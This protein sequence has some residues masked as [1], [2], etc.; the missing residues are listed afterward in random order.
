MLI[1]LSIAAFAT[2]TDLR[3]IMPSFS[4]SVNRLIKWISDSSVMVSSAILNWA[5]ST[6]SGVIAAKPSLIV[7]ADDSDSLKPTR[8]T[9]WLSI[10]ILLSF[11]KLKLGITSLLV[12][13]PSKTF[14]KVSVVRSIVLTILRIDSCR[15]GL[16]MT[17]IKLTNKLSF[18]SRAICC[19]NALR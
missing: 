15:S 19:V 8:R 16:G 6:L 5:L 4:V 2:G 10:K 11:K 3:L 7:W 17:S 1:P 9:P 13:L 12:S 18:N 14:N